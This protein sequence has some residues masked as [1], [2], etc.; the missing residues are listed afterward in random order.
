MVA[1]SDEATEAAGFG[2]GS[3]GFGQILD[4]A[5][6][7]NARESLMSVAASA[8][9]AGLPEASA[10]IMDLPVVVK[11]V[12]GSTRMALANVAK[13]S[14]GS[15]VRLDSKVGEPA[16]IFVNGRLI[17]RGEVVVLDQDDNRFGIVLSEIAP[18]TSAPLMIR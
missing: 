5:G 16:E 10:L 15:L 1:N 13:L 17:A 9:G 7:D 11:V 18:A 6:S 14:K 8:A 4:Q 3:D 2:E 12:L